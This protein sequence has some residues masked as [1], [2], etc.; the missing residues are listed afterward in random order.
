MP[1]LLACSLTSIRAQELARSLAHEQ[2][3]HARVSK[4]AAEVESWKAK[5]RSCRARTR[6]PSRPLAAPLRLMR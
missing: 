3:L 1:L 2:A 4:Q 6:L 5:A